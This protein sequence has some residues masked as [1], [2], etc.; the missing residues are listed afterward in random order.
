M[1]SE[2]IP[3]EILVKSEDTHLK[4]VYV[5]IR[6]GESDLMDDDILSV[7]CAPGLSNSA[8][9]LYVIL[10][11]VERQKEAHGIFFP[12]TLTGL[13]KVHPGTAERGAGITTIIKQVAELRRR[14]LL[15]LRAALHRNQP[16]LPVLVKVLRPAS[17]AWKST[18][19]SVLQVKDV[20][21]VVGMQ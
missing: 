9:R 12:I 11:G 8:F 5:E 19:G 4:K 21:L 6:K 20:E 18:D 1:S 2:G 10:L 14:G 16:D 17:R 7:A 3:K 13:K 15:E